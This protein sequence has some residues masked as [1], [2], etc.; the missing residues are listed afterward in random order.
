MGA[1][2]VYQRQRVV[3][4]WQS[5]QAAAKMRATS[6]GRAAVRSNDVD[7]SDGGFECDGLVN[8]EPIATATMMAP[9]HVSVVDITRRS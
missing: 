4:L 7:G 9:V 3:L 1:T 5:L 2:Y 6:S 8:C